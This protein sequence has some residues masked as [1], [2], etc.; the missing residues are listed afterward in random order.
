MV[1]RESTKKK[2]ISRVFRAIPWESIQSESKKY[3]TYF[4]GSSSAL[5]GVAAL[6]EAGEEPGAEPEGKA[7]AAGV[8]EAIATKYGIK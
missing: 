4:V 6:A 3:P 8:S 5:V 2:G 1:F 7:A